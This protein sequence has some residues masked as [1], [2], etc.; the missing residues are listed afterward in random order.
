MF[1]TEKQIN[2]NPI[3][4]PPQEWLDEIEKEEDEIKNRFYYNNFDCWNIITNYKTLLEGEMSCYCETCETDFNIKR[5]DCV[6]IE[7]NKYRC[8]DCVHNYK[9][10][11]EEALT[12][13][14]QMLQL[15]YKELGKFLKEQGVRNLSYLKKKDNRISLYRAIRIFDIVLPD[16]GVE[17]IFGVKHNYK[18]IKDFMSEGLFRYCSHICYRDGNGD[19]GGHSEWDIECFFSD[20]DYNYKDI[21]YRLKHDGEKIYVFD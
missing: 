19:G 10:I 13:F 1:L 20:Y 9:E 2:S 17:D 6:K 16:A 21:W 3:Y 4:K 8:E 18:Y 11:E 15:S 7:Y 5:K 14:W 12:E